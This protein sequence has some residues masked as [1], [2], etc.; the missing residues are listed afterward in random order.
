MMRMPGAAGY[1]K[2]MSMHT[3]TANKDISLA[4]EFKKHLYDPSCKN[5]VMD[6]GK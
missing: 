1:D 2:H 6:Q 5:N 4:R 3:L